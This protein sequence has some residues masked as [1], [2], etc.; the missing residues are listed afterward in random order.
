MCVLQMTT[1]YLHHNHILLVF[2]SGN[3]WPCGLCDTDHISKTMHNNVFIYSTI[4]IYQNPA[5]I[6]LHASIIQSVFWCK[7]WKITDHLRYTL[8][9]FTG[10]LGIVIFV[11]SGYNISFLSTNSWTLIKSVIVVKICTNLTLDKSW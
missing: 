11:Y 2:A 10:I 9:L 1:S 7:S 5:T 8:N 6:D 4:N 3:T